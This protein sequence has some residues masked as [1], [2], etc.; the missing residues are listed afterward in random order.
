MPLLTAR[1]LLG[2]TAVFAAFAIAVAIFSLAVGAEKID[3]WRAALAW[4]RGGDARHS[5]EAT[6]L[7]GLR[8]PRIMLAFLS[9]A[10]LAL[11]GAVF[12]AVLR[13]PLAE[14]YTLGVAGGGSFGAVLAIFLPARLPWIS[15]AWGP[16]NHVQ[17]L[18]FAGAVFSVGVIYFMARQ[19][20]RVSPVELL[21]AGVTMGVLFQALIMAVRYF[22]DP[23]MLIGM[24]R[25]M[26]G[27]LD[28]SG[29]SQVWPVLTFLVP[30]ALILL[31][32]GRGLDLVAFGEAFAEGRGLNVARLQKLA[33]FA[34]SLVTASI[35]AVTGPIG[36]VGIMVPHTIRRM[37]G[38]DHRLL[39]PCVLFGGGGFLVLCDTVART[40]LAP[41]ELP[42]GVITALLGGPFFLYLLIQSRRRGR[43]W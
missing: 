23:D 24:D 36:F 33:F 32:L 14:P 38:P 13:N 41:T 8:L 34:G 35:V 4:L 10:G 29:L 22:A 26:M 7:V 12:Q 11:V 40:I 30:G 21:L 5:A 20:G 3:P 15:F 37:I 6:I 42:V 9:G 28:V 16:I 27:G 31:G 1:R 39:L 2:V 25:W 43:R 18:A 17:C 19:S